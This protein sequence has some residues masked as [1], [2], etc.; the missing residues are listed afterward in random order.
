MALELL[1]AHV[2]GNR[3]VLRQGIAAE[4]L[5]GAPPPLPGQMPEN[6]WDENHNPNDLSK[7]RWGIVAPKG[8]VGDRLL[9]LIAP[10]KRAR[11]EAQGAPVIEYRFPPRSTGEVDGAWAMRWKQEVFRHEARMES[12]E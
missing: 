7:Q 6:L 11:E 1:L 3:P 9:E 8:A 5:R 4:T 2:D 12:S 10:L